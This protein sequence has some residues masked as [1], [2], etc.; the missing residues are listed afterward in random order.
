M[1]GAVV[2]GTA[3]ARYLGPSRFGL[4][5]YGLAIYGLFNVISNLGLDYLVVRDLSVDGGSEAEVLGSSFILKGVASV[6]TTAV[7]ILVSHLLEPHDHTL[8]LIVALM[9]F[10]SISQAL[11][12]ID[13]MFQANTQSRYAVVP[14]SIAFAVASVG[15]I[16]AILLHMSL[17]SFAWIAALEVLAGEIGLA[18]AYLR[19]RRPLLRWSWHAARAKGLLTESWPLLMSTVLIMIYMR[20]DQIL[21][22]KLASKEVV[23]QY[24]A[25]VRL[26]EIWYTLPMLVCDS[27]MPR[28]LRSRAAN[29]DVYLSRLQRLYEALILISF[30]T[31][32]VTQFAGGLVVRLLYGSKFAPAAAVLSVHIWTGVFVCV[33][34]VGGQQM[35]QEGLALSSL[36]RTTLGAIVNL[37]LNFLWIPR[38]G[39]IGSAMATLAAQGVAS[40]FADFF[41]ARTRSIFRMK[42]R[43]FLHFWLLPRMLFVPR[44]QD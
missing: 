32:L 29:Y 15:R 4:L 24:T 16:V 42:T 34:C 22:G 27:V 13:Y 9:S 12:V 23:G 28:L 31:A 5:N 6:V 33:G 41:D 35:I 3:V 30:S 25:A 43:A 11:D 36:K 40:Y 39:G 8:L 17:L 18:I 26:S 37:L 38:F 44:S 20:T 2:V 21:L 1:F 14:R 10:A 19:F 7:A